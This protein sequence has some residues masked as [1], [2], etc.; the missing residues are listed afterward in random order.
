MRMSLAIGLSLL[1]LA[2]CFV[3]VPILAATVGGW[4]AYWGPILL[5]T[6]WALVLLWLRVTKFWEEG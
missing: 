5:G 6:V 4:Y 2:I 1:V 3:S